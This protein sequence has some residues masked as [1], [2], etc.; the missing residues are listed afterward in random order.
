VNWLRLTA[1]AAAVT[2]VAALTVGAI[3]LSERDSHLQRQVAGL[4]AQRDARHAAF[5]A[6]L[7]AEAGVHSVSP[8]LSRL[9]VLTYQAE[10]CP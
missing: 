1:G 9:A 7:R 2:I 10:A 6:Y 8:G 4:T 5:C 3:A